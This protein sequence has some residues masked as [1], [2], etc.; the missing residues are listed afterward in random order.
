MVTLRLG[1]NREPVFRIRQ[2]SAKD[3]AGE[4]LAL[5][6][7]AL[8]LVASVAWAGDSE[9]VISGRRTADPIE[10]EIQLYR[11]NV[12]DGHVRPLTTDLNDYRDFVISAG[13]G[14]VAAIRHESLGSIW[15]GP[16][17]R[18]DEATEL[19]S[20]LG[21]RD[22]RGGIDWTSNNRLVL[23]GETDMPSVWTMDADGADPRRLTEGNTA[24]GPAA[25][26]DGQQILFD[27]DQASPDVPELFMVPA[28]GGAAKQVTRRNGA[29]NASISSDGR[30]IVFRTTRATLP[31]KVLKAPI[32]GGPATTLFEAA[33]VTRMRLSPDGRWLAVISSP[34]QV[35]P[36]SL[37]LVPFDGGEPREL[38]ANLTGAS[39]V[40]WFPDSR[41][42]GY[43]QTRDGNSSLWR[44]AIDGGGTPRQVTHL[45]RQSALQ[46][47]VSPDG[48]RIA[49]H[50]GVGQREIVLLKN[51]AASR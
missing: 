4:D 3:G 13:T 19:P 26:P 22:G 47:A 50:R 33:R 27:S 6:G 8:R 21:E 14:T 43:A 16:A 11:V 18:P 32:D 39:S 42:V 46:P 44:V 49:Y 51:V 31:I 5:S 23:L 36:Q 25:T 29:Y 7:V 40:A 15:V 48:R 24:Y 35:A 30:T 17:D 41:A 10:G 38:L 2:V 9:L 37:Y 12:A 1:E 20:R 34:R 28:G 45:T